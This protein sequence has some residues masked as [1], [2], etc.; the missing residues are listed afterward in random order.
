MMTRHF[1][2]NFDSLPSITI[3]KEAV[4]ALMRGHR[5]ISFQVYS[6]NSFVVMFV[7]MPYA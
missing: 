3:F 1:I 5:K 6:G 7:I 4:S 2:P